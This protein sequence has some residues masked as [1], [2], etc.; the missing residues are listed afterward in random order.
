MKNYIS[1]IARM[2]RIEEAFKRFYCS[3]SIYDDISLE[4]I[5]SSL[6]LGFFF[7]DTLEMINPKHVGNKVLARSTAEDFSTLWYEYKHHLEQGKKGLPIIDISYLG[8][9]HHTTYHKLVRSVKWLDEWNL[10]DLEQADKKT[11]NN[12][13]YKFNLDILEA[14]I[15]DEC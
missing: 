10:I 12:R 13:Y 2:N 15:L 9:K 1:E 6:P 3:N 4:N 11:P 8:K 5:P 7:K 14:M